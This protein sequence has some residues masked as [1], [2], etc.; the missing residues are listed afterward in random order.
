[1]YKAFKD[2]EVK[3]IDTTEKPKIRAL[4]GLGDVQK[5]LGKDPK[6]QTFGSKITKKER[7]EEN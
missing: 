3:K 6:F 4:V 5:D 1:M 7:A 2:K